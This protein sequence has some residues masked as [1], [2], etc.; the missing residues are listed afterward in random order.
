MH[1]RTIKFSLH[2]KDGSIGSFEKPIIGDDEMVKWV[3]EQYAE[4]NDCRVTATENGKQ[5][6]EADKP[7][8]DPKE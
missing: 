1:I 7:E 4:V 2:W 8:T 6:A 5:I 3:T